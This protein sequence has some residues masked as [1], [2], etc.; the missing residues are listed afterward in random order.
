MQTISAL[1]SLV[2]SNGQITRCRRPAQTKTAV[3]TPA[4]TT[5]GFLRHQ[6]LPLWE[7]SAAA[8]PEKNKTEREFFDSLSILSDK[9]Q[10]QPMDISDKPY[11][12]NILLAYW[13]AEQYLVR[14]DQETE[15]IIMQTYKNNVVLVNKEVYNTNNTLYYI[16]VLPLYKLLK[17]KL[18]KACAELLLSVFAYLYHIADIPYYRSEDSYLCY[19]YQMIK[20]WLMD[21]PEYSEDEYNLH[22]QS[23]LNKVA[24][25]GDVMVR[26]IYN[27]IHLEQ[28]AK[29]IQ[30]FRPKDEFQSDCLKVAQTA[31]NI[32]AQYPN[33]SIYSH[34]AQIEDE[35]VD[36]TISAGQYISFIADNDG[37]LYDE[38]TSMID[39]EF[40]ERIAIQEP[41]AYTIYSAKET[42]QVLDME[43]QLFPLINDLCS[44]LNKI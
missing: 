11:P 36:E 38:M 30:N 12:Y 14:Q 3:H 20:D 40:G 4:P 33:S 6:F 2:R 29:R 21:D 5:D 7:Q 25:I 18:Q 8:L 19:M 17:D 44:L 37:S 22:K 32:M 42:P 1:N 15:L 31:H 24:H 27:T 26:K 9:H 10:F 23:E 35:D 39:G 13:Q 28:F 43:Q 16:P 41:T 34:M